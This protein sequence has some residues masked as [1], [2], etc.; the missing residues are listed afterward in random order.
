MDLDQK[1]HNQESV[2]SHTP[3]CMRVSIPF[4]RQ[5]GSSLD[6]A[7][8]PP[9]KAAIET[10]PDF[11]ATP[12]LKTDLDLHTLMWI[13]WNFIHMLYRSG[14]PKMPLAGYGRPKLQET[15]L[16]PRRHRRGIC[17]HQGFVGTKRTRTIA[18]RLPATEST[19]VERSSIA[20][21]VKRDSIVSRGFPLHFRR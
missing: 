17:N 2:I 13:F 3:L 19:L 8:Q 5:T 7:F 4:H 20:W 1:V 14:H 16:W 15:R 6:F 12:C 11:S 21:L 9:W 18:L 10:E